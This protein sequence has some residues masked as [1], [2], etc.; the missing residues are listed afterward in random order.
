MQQKCGD[1]RC[2]G[3]WDQGERH[4]IHVTAKG[5]CSWGL[6]EVVYTKAHPHY[7]KG[8]VIYLCNAC[9]SRL[10][11]PRRNTL[12]L[13][14]SPSCNP[15]LQPVILFFLYPALLE[16]SPRSCG[17]DWYRELARPNASPCAPLYRHALPTTSS[18]TPLLRVGG[19]IR[20][21]LMSDGDSLSKEHE[22]A[23]PMSYERR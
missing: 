9:K 15:V 4:E 17:H 20:K 22:G 5:R 11:A 23:S 2:K 6:I 18:P 3:T 12:Q 14:P 1:H 19:A 13:E 21:K 16:G 10:R 7:K 8:R